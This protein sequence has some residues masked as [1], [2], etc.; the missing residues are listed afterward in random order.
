MNICERYDE[1]L[2]AYDRAIQLDST[3]AYVFSNKGLTLN[4]MN[5]H[6]LAISYFDYAILLK[7]DFVEAVYKEFNSYSI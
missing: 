5:K 4:N 1:A 2:E 7:P 6:E 3:Y